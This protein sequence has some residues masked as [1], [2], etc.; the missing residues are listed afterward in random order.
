MLK[1]VSEGASMTEKKRDGRG[2]LTVDLG[3]P[4]KR[5]LEAFCKRTERSKKATTIRALRKHM[6]EEEAKP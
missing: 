1:M 4:L 6:Q 3:L 5:R 2:R